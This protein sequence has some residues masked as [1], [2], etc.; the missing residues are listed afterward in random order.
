MDA[1]NAGEFAFLWEIVWQSTD[2]DFRKKSSDKAVYKLVSR[3]EVANKPKAFSFVDEYGRVAGIAED[4]GVW[5]LIPQI[6]GKFKH[7][8]YRRKDQVSA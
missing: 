1:I 4:I 8:Q 7:P 3:Q 6:R 5:A 2:S